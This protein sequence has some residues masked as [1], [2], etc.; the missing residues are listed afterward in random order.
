MPTKGAAM[1][2]FGE[3]DE[4]YGSSGDAP[5]RARRVRRLLL[6]IGVL[7]AAAVPITLAYRA[8]SHHGQQEVRS[9]GEGGRHDAKLTQAR[10]SGGGRRARRNNRSEQLR[11]RLLDR[12]DPPTSATQTT[13]S[14]CPTSTPGTGPTAVCAYAVEGPQAHGHRQGHRRALPK[15]MVASAHI[16]GGLDVVVHVDSSTYGKTS[17]PRRSRRRA[18]R[19][20]AS[21]SRASHRS[22][23]ARSAMGGSLS[24]D[25]HGQP[26]RLL[27]P[28]QAVD[29]RCGAGRHVHGRR[30][31]RDGLRGRDRPDAAGR[32]AGLSNDKRTSITEALDVMSREGYTDTRVRVSVD[33]A[34]FIRRAVSVDHYRDGG[35]ITSRRRTRTSGAPARSDARATFAAAHLDRVRLARRNPHD[36]HDH[37]VERALDLARLERAPRRRR[38]Q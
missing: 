8:R 31:A 32:P 30:P 36:D 14:P 29:H 33:D 22:P 3:S 7:V 21:R 13:A 10:R 28:R 25:R 23:R 18:V 6:V 37:P 19:Q 12:R 11:P 27:G 26:E 35:T 16:G 34:G 17:A 20:L 4:T 2:T 38:P 9:T 1:S 5:D 15:A 24:H